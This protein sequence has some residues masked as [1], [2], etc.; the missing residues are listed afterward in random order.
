MISWEYDDNRNFDIYFWFSVLIEK[1]GGFKFS[2]KFLVCFLSSGNY[3]SW[4]YNPL[5]DL[6]R[7]ET[8]QKD[9]ENFLN[10]GT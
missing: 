4:L 6:R 3:G 10:R 8:S 9:K 7:P 5:S 2:G 1:S